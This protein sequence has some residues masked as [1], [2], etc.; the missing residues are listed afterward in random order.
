MV[1]LRSILKCTTLIVAFRISLQNERKVVIF[2]KK[3]YA[4]KHVGKFVQ[5]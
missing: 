3:L 1:V 4:R 2:L 5:K